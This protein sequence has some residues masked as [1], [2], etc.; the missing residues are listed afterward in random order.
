MIADRVILARAVHDPAAR[1]PRRRRL[2][3]PD[4]DRDRRARHRHEREGAAAVRPALLHGLRRLER[5]FEPRRR[6]DLR[7]VGVAVPPTAPTGSACSPSSPAGT[8]ARATPPMSR[9]RLPIGEVDRRDP[10]GRSTRSSRGWR[11]RSTGARGSIR[12]CRTRGSVAP[13]P[14]SCR[15]SSTGSGARWSKPQGAVHLAGEQTSTYSQGYLN[16][17]VE[18]GGRAAAE[19]LDALGLALPAGIVRSNRLARRFRPVFPGRSERRS[20]CRVRDL[21]RSAVSLRSG[22]PAPTRWWQAPRSSRS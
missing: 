7:H 10:R 14:P 4:D 17:G 21:D 8:S 22:V 1:R 19:V 9:T 16:G 2:L 3:Q 6:A 18:S 13:T 15:V 5:R 20:A 12:G 11:R